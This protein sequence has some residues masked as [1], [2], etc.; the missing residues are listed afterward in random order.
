M[1]V[2]VCMCVCACVCIC[3]YVYVCVCMC[4]YMYVCVCV[5]VC[6]C[7]CVCTLCTQLHTWFKIFGIT[8]SVGEL[9]NSASLTL[10]HSRVCCVHCMFGTRASSPPPTHTHTQEGQ[11]RYH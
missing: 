6:V 8:L 10:S 9:K 11:S 4:V 1:C 2:C 7:M 5:H 3:M